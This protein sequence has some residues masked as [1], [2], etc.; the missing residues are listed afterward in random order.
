MRWDKLGNIIKV[1]KAFD[2]LELCAIL[3]ALFG[4]LNHGGWW[5][6]GCICVLV[7]T[8]IPEI[9]RILRDLRM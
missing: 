3:A 2:L 8:S 5:Y 7:L 1:R 9:L 4:G 6:A